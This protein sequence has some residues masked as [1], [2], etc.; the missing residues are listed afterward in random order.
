MK[1]IKNYLYNAGYQLLNIILPLLTAPYI[2]RVLK[3]EGVGINSYTNSLIQ[4]FVLLAGIGIGYY[5]NREI[6]YVR[7]D[8]E[9]MTQAFWEIQI[10][11]VFMTIIS[12]F[13]FTLFLQVYRKY[14]IYLIF[15][16][17]NVI[18]AA[19]DIS[20]FYMG[21]EDFKRTVLRNT[22][23]KIVS[24]IAIFSFVKD[25]NDVGLYIIILAC[26]ALLG[27]ITL[28][29]HLKK[30]LTKVVWN[31]LKPWKHF[32]P[33]VSLFIPQIATQIY[34][35]L[36]KNM[37]GAIVGSTSS[38]MY[39][40]SDSIIKMILAIVTATGTVMLPHVSHAFAEG[41]N[42][43]VNELLYSSFDFVS[44]IAIP[45]TF[46]LMAVSKYL[47]LMIFGPGFYAVGQAM[48]GEASVIVLIGWSNVIGAQYLLPTDRVKDFTMSV[49][50]GA[51]SN[52]ILNIPFIYFWGLMGAVFAT[53][54]SEL[55]VTLYQFYVVRHQLKLTK[56]IENLWKYLIAGMIM[57]VPVYYLEE[58]WKPK[59]LSLVAAGHMGLEILI[60]ILIYIGVI[61][62]L[63]PTII[64]KAKYLQK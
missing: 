11:K 44:F 57:F 16:S 1:V 25:A 8:K 3:P 15:Q 54:L 4:W 35:I 23:V 62:I 26:S 39:N 40:S 20:W 42:K 49:T 5:G 9:K 28:W 34:L 14:Y 13:A 56:M 61:L 10:L 27:N 18:A 30:V 31:K 6:A 45:L 50:L 19:F 43:K 29:P 36:N 17:L 33:T 58:T 7:N 60:G 46:G 12:F 64:Y 63:K 48:M 41:D 53:V 37:L 21:I 38:G 32:V 22:I 59:D 24:L 51:V 2:G 47:G 55:V 52:I